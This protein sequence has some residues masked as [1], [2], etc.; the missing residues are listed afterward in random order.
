MVGAQDAQAVGQVL[1]VQ[2][3][4][5]LG[6]ARGLIGVGEVVARGEGVGVVGPQEALAVGQVLL[7]QVDGLVGVSGILWTWGEF[8]PATE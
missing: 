4:G 6:S 2:A 7:E 3:D 8:L 5:L 1:L